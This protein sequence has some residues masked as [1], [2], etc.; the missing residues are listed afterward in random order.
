MRSKVRGFYGSIQFD[1]CKAKPF[2][3]FHVLPKVN[4]RAEKRKRGLKD[5]RMSGQVDKKNEPIS[6]S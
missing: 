3:C 1:Y 6:Y 2:A 4:L 5:S